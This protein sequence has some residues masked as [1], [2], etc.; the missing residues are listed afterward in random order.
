MT[1]RGG[2]L[3]VSLSFA[4]IASGVLAEQADPDRIKPHQTVSHGSPPRSPVA[5]NPDPQGVPVLPEPLEAVPFTLEIEVTNIVSYGTPPLSPVQFNPDPG[6]TERPTPASPPPF[7]KPEFTLGLLY[8]QEPVP[9]ALTLPRCNTEMKKIVEIEPHPPPDTRRDPLSPTLQLPRTEVRANERIT[10]KWEEPEYTRQTGPF[11]SPTN[12]SPAIDRWKV[13]FASWQRYT[14]SPAETPYQHEKTALWDPYQQSLLKGDAPIIGQ[15]IFLDLTAVS[16]TLFQGRRLPTPSGVSA[17]TPGSAGFFGNG[18]ELFVSQ[19]FSFTADLFE[20]ET[21]FQPVHWMIRL[22]PV[23]N[24]NYLATE[25]RGVVSPNPVDGL[26]RLREYVALQQVFGELHLGDL[27]DNYDFIACRA[28]NQPFISDFR[29]FIFDDVNLGARIFGNA[30]NNRWQ[31]NA[32]VLPMREKDTDSGLNTF[33]DRDQYVVIANVYRQDF[34]TPGYTAQFSFHANLDDG[35]THYDNNGNIVRPSPIGTVVQHDVQAYYL[36]WTGDGHVGRLNI[37]HAFYEALGRDDLNGLAGRSVTINAQMAAAELSYDHDWIRYKLSLFYASGDRN[38]GDGTATGFDGIVDNP[39]FAG[40]PFS[41]WTSQGINLA[42]TSV[43]LKQPDSL[44]PN[45]RTSKTE[46][47]ANFVN[48]GLVLVGVGTDLDITPKLRG[49]L[50]VNYLRFAET[51]PIKAALLTDKVDNEIGLDCSVGVRYRP[52]LT[53][54]IVVTAG[55]G[56]LIPGSG[57]R[58]IYAHGPTPTSTGGSNNGQTDDFLYSGLVKL[59]FTY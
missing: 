15:D 44:L 34:L 4:V 17:Q 16:D 11:E 37:T 31:Y 55:F 41:Y 42:G 50:N 39:A 35:R 21:V 58:D 56:V 43:A 53:D 18:D 13:P 12:T 45:L 24:I 25:E 32:I 38:S 14:N 3:G 52:L 29:G 20:G 59:T 48:P 19:N 2:V 26:N 7:F 30:D 36:G 46:G 54:N 8:G 9:G 10:N 49:F 57:F 23:F 5:F 28:G 40:A 22:E 27:S 33:D 1:R 51:D 6:A 47:Q